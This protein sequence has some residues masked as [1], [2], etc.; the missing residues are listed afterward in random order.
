MLL[1]TRRYDMKKIIVVSLSILIFSAVICEYG[2]T[3]GE[4]QKTLT[5]DRKA[6]KAQKKLKQEMRA[7]KHARATEI[8]EELLPATF[9]V[10]DFESFPNNLGGNV[11]VFGGGEPDWDNKEVPHGWYY[12][13]TTQGFTPKNVHAGGQ[14]FRCVN[15]YSVDRVRW[16]TLSFD[17][18]KIVDADVIPIRI[19]SLNVSAYKS[20]I[21][22]VKG[23]R[24]GEMFRVFFRDGRAEDYFP[25]V[26]LEPFPGGI[27]TQWT[28]V[29]IPLKRV[30][31][32]VD[33]TL[34]DQ[35]GLEFGTNVGN[36]E[37]NIF[38]IDDI[39]FSKYEVGE[40]VKLKVYPKQ[41]DKAQ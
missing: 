23:D 30:V 2:F 6:R 39:H 8:P 22:W 32:Y 20:L 33:L 18:G 25:Q 21:F 16:A 35:I 37:G 17:L 24:G 14:S 11:G 38:Y 26:T 29:V 28:K 40:G 5:A 3:E 7:R 10:A 27:S 15:G 13:K 34:L 41:E 31:E 9:I 4:I 12:S 36:A 19:K 1:I